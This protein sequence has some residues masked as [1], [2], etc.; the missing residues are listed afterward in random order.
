MV[1][2]VLV[3]IIGAPVACG[4]EVT[5]TW[6]QLSALVGGQLRRRYGKAVQVEYFDLFDPGCPP[7][8]PNAELPLVLVDGKVVTSGGKLSVPLIRRAVDA[9]GVPPRTPVMS[10]TD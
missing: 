1:K 8:P 7:L 10:G 3:R 4:T 9:S 2:P 5:D 6:R